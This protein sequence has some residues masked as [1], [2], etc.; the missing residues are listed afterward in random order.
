MY[1]K[2]R[3]YLY[4]YLL[5]FKENLQKC[6]EGQ[7]LKHISKQRLEKLLIKV[8]SAEDQEKV[9]K[10]IDAINKEEGDFSNQVKAL[11][12]SIVK[13][14]QCVEQLVNTNVSNLNQEA[15]QT[16]DQQAESD[17]ES[18]QEQLDEE[19]ESDE[20]PVEIEYKKKPPFG[21]FF[22]FKQII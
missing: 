17:D 22:V 19:S 3:N 4:S 13:L 10:M 5:Y 11:K 8:P 1:K 15:D 12:E 21:G 18:E 7:G 20:E 9:V 2:F 6:Y 14:Y 16:I